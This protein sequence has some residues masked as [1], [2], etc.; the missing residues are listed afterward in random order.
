MPVRLEL[1]EQSPVEPCPCSPPRALQH[2]TSL[3]QTVCVSQRREWLDEHFGGRGM[4]EVV[5]DTTW[6]YLNHL[7]C[8][9]K[10]L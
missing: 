3:L 9:L 7:N 4:N 6:L 10:L 2:N 1:G 5:F 8:W